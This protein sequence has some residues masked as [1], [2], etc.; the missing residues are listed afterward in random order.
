MAEIAATASLRELLR[1]YYQSFFRDD[2]AGGRPKVAW[3][4]SV[5]PAELLTALGFRVYFPEN[6]GAMLG[7]TREA[8]RY[9]PGATAVGYSPDICSYLTADVGAYL[10]GE[11]P[12]K[13]AYGIE[14]PPRPD[15][16]V[17][18][19]NQCREMQDWFGFYSRE[20][21]VPS[22]GIHSPCKVD[23]LTKDH[24]DGVEAQLRDLIGRLEPLSGQRFDVDRLREVVRLSKAS[25]DLWKRFLERAKL[26]PSPI[27]FF[28]GCI[29]MAPAV[30]L[31]GTPEAVAYYERLNAELD[32]KTGPE[33]AAVPREKVRIYWDGMPLWG[34]LRFFSDLFARFDAAVVASTYCSSWVFDDFSPAAPLRSLAEA[35]TK[36]F[37]N[38]SETE[39]ERLLE[40]L[41]RDYGID[42]VI[43]HDAKTCPYNS[44]SRFGLPQRLTERSG[45]P[46]LVVNGDL[47]DLRC[48]SEDQTIT[49]VETFVEQLVQ[50]KDGA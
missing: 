32:G 47:N 17:Y 40:G 28:D 5:G 33:H 30:V 13:K 31:R 42:G 43:Y 2:G 48:F 9:I 25:S 34:K 22:L 14:A 35:Y 16:L 24:V 21:G 45:V 8:N 50:A 46:H 15:V 10:K 27:T 4:S 36:I 11:T 37:I 18:N 7:A 41:T 39:K 3:C 12:L 49:L 20:Y 29:Q 44:N 38:R 26:R 19:T 23:V 6:H 1:D